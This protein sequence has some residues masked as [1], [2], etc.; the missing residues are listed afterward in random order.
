MSPL[1]IVLWATGLFAAM[2]LATEAGYRL[3]RRR[4]KQEASSGAGVVEGAV[5]GLLGLLLAFAFSGAWGRFDSRIQSVVQEANAISTAYSYVSLLA[6]E[7]QPAMQAAFRDYMDTRLNMYRNLTQSVDVESAKREY[8]RGVELRTRI[9]DLATAAVRRPGYEQTRMLLLP[10]IN[11]AFDAATTRTVRTLSHLPG[12]VPLLIVVV[13][14]SG[15]MLT[16]YGTAGKGA[17]QWIRW[18]MLAGVTSTTSYLVL[19]LEYPRT[20]L[21]SMNYVDRAMEDVRKSMGP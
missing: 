20:G 13:S 8:V 14:I 4:G 6:P 2:L 17:R 11:N 16:G 5:F 18:V 3:A 19:D 9:W 15:S 10:S 7:D 1:T 12:V 21:I